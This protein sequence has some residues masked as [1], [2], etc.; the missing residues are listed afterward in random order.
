[1]A[2]TIDTYGDSAVMAAFLTRSFAS[3]GHEYVDDVITTMKNFAFAGITDLETLS[4]PSIT[5]ISNCAFYKTEVSGTVTIPWSQ[6][7]S[8]GNSAFFEGNVLKDSAL[9]LPALKEIDSGAFAGQTVLTSFSAPNLTA[10]YAGTGPFNSTKGVFEESGIQTFSAPLLD[11]SNFATRAFLNCT[12][13]TNV[14][15]NSMRFTGERMFEGCTSLTEISLPQVSS[16]SYSQVFRN[17]TALTTVSLP[18]VTSCSGM[19][20]FSGCTA[21]EEISLPLLETISGSSMFSGCTALQEVNFPVATNLGS[22]CFN[23]CISLTFEGLTIPYVYTLGGSCFYECTGLTEFSST[24][25]MTIG[26]SCFAYCSNLEEIFFSKVTAIPSSAFGY[27]S[28]LSKVTFSGAVTSFAD[29]AFRGCRLLETMILSR[30]TAVPTIQSSTFQ[31]AILIVNRIGTI[32]VPDAL[33]ASFQAHSTWGQYSIDAISN[34]TP[35]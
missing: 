27:C 13:L 4:L 11:S 6:I 32:Y 2:N 7:E 33:V 9:S 35:V 19:S 21:L 16:L 18:K 28:K 25:I 3:V 5:M 12:A 29:N 17:C 15:L 20:V 23:G 1:M 31:N 34:Y 30:V 8:I 24:R 14:N 22:G 10:A 26:S